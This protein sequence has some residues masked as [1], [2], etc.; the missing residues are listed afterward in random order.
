MKLQTKQLLLTMSVLALGML[1]G[2]EQAYA[3]IT[4]RS[5]GLTYNSR[6][7]TCNW[8]RAQQ[9]P[10]HQGQGNRHCRDMRPPARD[11]SGFRKADGNDRIPYMRA[12]IYNYVKNLKAVCPGLKL[13]STFR[14]CSAN[15]KA[16]GVS[17][18]RHL[19][20]GGA[21]TSGCGGVTA[22]AV[23]QRVCRSTGLVFINE[24]ASR[25]PHCQIQGHCN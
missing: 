23:A 12:E 6:T 7:K 24:G 13:E 5:V 4:C 3:K 20:G 19:C 10:R 9:R 16:R 2:A 22:K 14:N 21:D 18:S 8:N 1:S 25:Y 15:A 11:V 17:R